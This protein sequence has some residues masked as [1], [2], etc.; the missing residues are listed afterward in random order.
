[1]GTG[2]TGFIWKPPPPTDHNMPHSSTPYNSGVTHV[3]LLNRTFDV[4]IISPLTGNPQD[5]ATITAEVSAAA[6][7]Q[8]S[9]EFW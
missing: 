8:A 5:I 1:M 2:L 4:S 7:A 3:N 6:V 9:K